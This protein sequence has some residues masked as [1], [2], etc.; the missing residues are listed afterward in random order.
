MQA[1]EMY[2]LLHKRPFEP[3]RIHLSDGR[4]FDI[5]YPHMNMVGVTWIHIGVLAPGDTDSDPI[6]DHTVKVPL[7]LIS[8]VEPL[9]SLPTPSGGP[10]T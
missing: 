4:V 7:S 10:K 9:H 5:R 6:P 2:H 3:F 1:E 8:K